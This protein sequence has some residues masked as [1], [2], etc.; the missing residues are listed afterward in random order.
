VEENTADSTPVETKEQDSPIEAASRDQEDEED[1]IKQLKQK[2]RISNTVVYT[3]K[4]VNDFS[5]PSRDVTN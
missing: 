2:V 3:V 4:K 1:S 5:V